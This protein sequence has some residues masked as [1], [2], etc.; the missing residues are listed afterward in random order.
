MAMRAN[1]RQTSLP[2][3]DLITVLCR[4]AGVP[5]DDTRHIGVTPSSSTNIRCIEAECTREEAD[6]RR[7]AP[8]DTSPEVNIDSI[9]TEA[10][11]PTPASGP[12][13]LLPLLLLHTSRG[14][15]FEVTT[16][17][18]E[19]VD[20]I[21][22]VEYLKSTI[23]TSLL[24]AADDLDAPDTSKIPPATTRD[25]HRDDA[26]VDESDAETEEEQIEMQEERLYRDFPD[27]EEMIV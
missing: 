18:V 24:E 3:P 16:L 22:D 20:L 19:V 9:P 5:R 13:V 26:T 7:A 4:H 8:V 17:K 21:K 23:F 2:F 10:S 27:L 1:K 11:L 25:V 12:S 15:T 14:E 6:R